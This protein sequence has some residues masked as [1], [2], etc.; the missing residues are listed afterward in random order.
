[1]ILWKRLANFILESTPKQFKK[2]SFHQ[3]SKH[4][5]ISFSN[6]WF[7]IVL[8]TFE[9]LLTI[10]K[11]CKDNEYLT[12]TPLIIQLIYEIVTISGV[13][14]ILAVKYDYWAHPM[15]EK[16]CFL[17]LETVTKSWT[18]DSGWLWNIIID[19]SQINETFWLVL[20]KIWEFLMGLNHN[21]SSLFPMVNFAICMFQ[22]WLMTL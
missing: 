16:V 3:F 2:Y 7:M 1:M 19:F 6:S 4:N 11:P 8:H 15:Y 10:C 21:V 22:I 18:E 20:N 13:R 5:L 12:M 14:N 9:N 17:I